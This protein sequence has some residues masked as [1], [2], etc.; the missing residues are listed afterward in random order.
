MTRIKCLDAEGNP[1]EG[2]G[3]DRLGSE[4][5]SLDEAGAGSQTLSP[6]SSKPW[7]PL[8][9]CMWTLHLCTYFT[10]GTK[11]STKMMYFSACV[12]VSS[13]IS[14]SVFEKK[15]KVLKNQITFF[16]GRLLY[17]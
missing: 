13:D 10:R 12:S 7:Q 8:P 17:H 6:L 1:Y 15:Y 14:S 16:S 11:E 5:R 3:S 2:K 4:R 9:S